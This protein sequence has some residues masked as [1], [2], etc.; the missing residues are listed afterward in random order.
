MNTCAAT[1]GGGETRRTVTVTQQ[2]VNTRRNVHADCELWSTEDGGCTT[3][4]VQ[5]DLHRARNPVDDAW[6]ELAANLTTRSS[7]IVSRECTRQ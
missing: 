6:R 7:H 5:R 4:H 2:R 1:R 3:H